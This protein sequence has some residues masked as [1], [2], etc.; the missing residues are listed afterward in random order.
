MTFELG[1]R[2]NI[3]RIIA[4]VVIFALAYTT[5]CSAPAEAKAGFHLKVAGKLPGAYRHGRSSNSKFYNTQG[6]AFDTFSEKDAYVATLN[7]N[8]RRVKISHMTYKKGK[9][10][11]K[12]SVIYSKRQLGHANDLAVYR[13]EKETYLFVAKGGDR[14][15]KKAC[16]IKVSDF[17]KKKKKVYKVSFNK[18]D[19]RGGSDLRGFT[20][21]G[22]ENGKEIFIV[23]TGRTLNKVYLKS[24]GN[25]AKFVY[26]DSQRLKAPKKGGREGTA[27]GIVYHNGNI[28]CAYAD[29]ARGGK[30][31]TAMVSKTNYKKFFKTKNR[32]KAVK[33][34]STY[35]KSFSNRFITEAVFFTTQEG[36]DNMYITCNGRHRSKH[37]HMDY[38]YK[39]SQ[40]H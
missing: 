34:K 29:E 11:R 2:K 23:E 15:S 12:K 39:S 19:R 37:K 25:G 21:V 8:E 31:R 10:K 24:I 18:L 22:N 9:F 40:K 32:R 36:D 30:R 5:L 28:Y 7:T 17:K 3:F 27:S 38:I 35:R 26:M 6:M 20:Y 33:F 14:N 13:T 4:F 16:M 1:I